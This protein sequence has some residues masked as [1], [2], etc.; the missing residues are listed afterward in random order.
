MIHMHSK[1]TLAVSAALLLSSLSALGI[2][3]HRLEVEKAAYRSMRAAEAEEA[4][5]HAA[6]SSLVSTFE[7]TA[8][9]RKTLNS[10]MLTEE[11][12]IDLLSLIETLGRES[13]ALLST[14]ELKVESVNT[15][16]E[17]LVATVSA[18]GSYASVMHVLELLEQ[19]PYQAT[20]E[21]VNVTHDT[22]TWQGIFTLHILKFKGT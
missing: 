9:A 21:T 3:L 15:Q 20:I 16:F 19:L 10:H 2:F 13:G 22:D 6:L 17:R 4:A 1:I 5:R 8:D 12:V 11:G 7:K 14:D 18:E